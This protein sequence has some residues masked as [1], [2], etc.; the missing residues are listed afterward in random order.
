VF[1]ARYAALSGGEK[2]DEANNRHLLQQLAGKTDR[3]AC[4]VAVLVYLRHADDPRPII[5]QGEWQ[6]RIATQAAGTNGFGYDPYFYLPTHG[7]TVAQ[8]QAAEKNSL[9]HRAQ[10]L[11]ELLRVLHRP[12]WPA[13]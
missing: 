4:Y 5:A 7:K 10:A 9:S 1:S 13:A 8:M 12:A 11:R 3:S 2:S 6:G